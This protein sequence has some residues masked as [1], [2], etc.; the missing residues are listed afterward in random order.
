[1]T[2]GTVVKWHRKEGEKVRAG[3]HVALKTLSRVDPAGIEVLHLAQLLADVALGAARQQA[4]EAAWA[5]AST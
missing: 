2:V 1:M 5:Q 4:A 3:E